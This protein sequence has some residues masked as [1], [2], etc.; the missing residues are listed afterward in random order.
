MAIADVSGQSITELL[1]LHGRVAVVTGAARGIGRASAARLAEAG[2]TAST[3]TPAGP[4]S[5][6]VARVSP[7]TACFDVM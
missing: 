1:S 6:A 4:N 2:A 5:T 3:R 7:T